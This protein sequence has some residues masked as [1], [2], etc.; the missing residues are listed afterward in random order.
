LEQI[1]LDLTGVVVL[2]RRRSV[3]VIVLCV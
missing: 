1:F 3:G 2:L